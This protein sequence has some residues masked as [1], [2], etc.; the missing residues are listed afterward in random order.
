MTELAGR[1]A[2]VTGG[3]SGLGRGLARALAAAGAT[4][5]VADLHGDDATSVAEEI[6]GAGGSALG[7]ACDV[8]ERDAVMAL[9]RTAEEAF[10]PVTLLFANAGATSLERLADLTVGDVDWLLQVNLHGVV[11][12][13]QAFVPGMLA[14]GSGHVVATASMAGLLP[15]LLPYHAPYVA[16]KAGIIGLLLNLRTELAEAGVGC[17]VVCPGGVRSAIGRS[18]SYRTVRYGG[19]AEDRVG[20]P[21]GFTPPAALHFREPAEVAEMV[22]RAV[23]ADRAM[24]VTDPHQRD[25]FVAGYV[26]VV[27]A[28]FDDAAAF[29]AEAGS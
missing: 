25:D 8:C 27:L 23:Q 14:A 19:P 17:T 20:R 24:V 7:V 5:V 3:G 10:G 18:P 1:V 28:A 13:V 11:H 2:V 6:A 15:A 26:D 22:L 21:R 4:V 29:D 12:C 16:A 9:Q